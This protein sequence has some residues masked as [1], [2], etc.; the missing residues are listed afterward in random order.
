MV[1]G[2]LSI[3][4]SAID[5][6]N[7]AIK[8]QKQLRQNQQLICGSVCTPVIYLLKMKQFMAMV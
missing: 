1:M 6:V 8:I 7:S 3:F 5:A 4:S 2:A